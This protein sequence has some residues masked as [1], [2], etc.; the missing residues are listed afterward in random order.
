MESL[1]LSSKILL[2]RIYVSCAL[3]HYIHNLSLV[4]SEILQVGFVYFQFLYR[5]RFESLGGRRDQY[6]EVIFRLTRPFLVFII[7]LMQVNN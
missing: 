4:L 2:F 5:N 3:L 6:V 1:V 7:D